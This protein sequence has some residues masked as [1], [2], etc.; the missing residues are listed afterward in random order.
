MSFE[1]IVSYI[2]A[3]KKE[4]ISDILS[5]MRIKSVR[6]SP[7]PGMP[8]GEGPAQALQAAASMAKQYGFQVTN[9]D[10][11]VIAVDFSP[12]EPCLDILAHLDVVPGGNGWTVT[13]PFSP[14]VQNDL[15]YGRGSSDDKGPAVAAL[16]AMR[17]IRELHIPLKKNVR[18]ILGADEE[19]G[20]S[21]LAYYYQH[22]KEAPMS[23]SPDADF[24]VVNVEKGRFTPAFGQTLPDESLL[25]ARILSIQAGDKIN[26]VP[27][28]ASA[29]LTGINVSLVLKEAE[30]ITKL[31]QVSFSVSQEGNEIKILAE[32]KAAHASTPEKGNNAATALLQLLCVLPLSEGDSQKAVHLLASLFPHCT[33]NGA[34]LGINMRDEVSG[35][36]TIS[37]NLISLQNGKLLCQCDS[38]IPVCSNWENTAEVFTQKLEKVGLNVYSNEIM[39]AHQVPENSVFVQTLLNCYETVTGKPGTC[40]TMG[41]LTYVHNLKNGVAFGCA[42]PETDNHMHGA[43]EFASIQCLCD[44]AKMFALAIQKICQ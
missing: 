28:N 11:Y 35:D 22:E 2:E 15:I 16:Y 36:L 5:L 38:R 7:L 10:N 42:L 21:D 24:P 12:M 31:T 17:A 37:L 43:N 39:P 20:S 6:T 14:I 25:P 40:L 18:L 27:S 26:V 33:W 29:I 30:A 9:Y 41:G 8:F 13:D 19:C 32:G 44:S 1:K 4:M 23:F 3:H 34:P